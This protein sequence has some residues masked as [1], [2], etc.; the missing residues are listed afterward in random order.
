MRQM[1]L[2]QKP[3][4]C[5]I[6]TLGNL[7]GGVL[8]DAQA[9]GVGVAH[10]QT[11]LRSLWYDWPPQIMTSMILWR[12]LLDTHSHTIIR[13][14]MHELMRW[15]YGDPHHHSM[16]LSE[17]QQEI[18]AFLNARA[19]VQSKHSVFSFVVRSKDF[20]TLLLTMTRHAKFSTV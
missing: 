3:T 18:S 16:S 10:D 7:R 14:C 20:D 19:F 12:T 2:L 11:R 6:N 15:W 17:L 13:V 8:H 4:G 9:A 5:M 1:S